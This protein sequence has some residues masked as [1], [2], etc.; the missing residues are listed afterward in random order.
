MGSSFDAAKFTSAM[1]KLKNNQTRTTTDNA[2]L[3]DVVRALMYTDDNTMLNSI[4]SY[5]KTLR[6][7]PK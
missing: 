7:E 3:G 1:N 6:T 5:L 2:F 4:F